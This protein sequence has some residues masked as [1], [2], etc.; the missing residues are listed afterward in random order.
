MIQRNTERHI[1]RATLSTFCISKLGTYNYFCT[2]NC[3]SLSEVVSAKQESKLLE[4][5]N[6]STVL[7]FLTWEYL[8]SFSFRLLQKNHRNFIKNKAE[9]N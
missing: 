1:E 7:I 2:P 5:S 3:E 8:F 6:C 4:Y 9:I